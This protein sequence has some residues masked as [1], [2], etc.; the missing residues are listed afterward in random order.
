MLNTRALLLATLLGTVLQVGMVVAGH[1]NKSIAGLFAIGGMGF[2]LIAG[3]AYAFWAGGGT[4]TLLALGGLAAGAICALIGIFVSYGMGDVPA[5]LLALGTLSSAVTGALGGIIGKFLFRAAGVVAMFAVL[6]A[7]AASAGSQTAIPAPIDTSAVISDA[8]I[9]A[10]LQAVWDA[11]ATSEGLRSWLAPQADID[12]RV[13]GLLRANYN[14]KGS[15]ADPQTIH[16][17][18]LSLDPG[19]MLSIKVSKAPEGF[20]FANAIQHM[21]TVVY[22]EPA[23][24]NLT[25]V[26]VVGLG[27]RADPESQRMRAFFDQGNATTLK[28]L[29]RRFAKRGE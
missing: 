15:L 27:F 28:Q 11:W 5:S 7:T 26:R 20:P 6:T 25:R 2:S 29:Q 24:Q 14:A 12:L 21:W 16:N 19:R 13:G 8:I 18:V 9:E 1:S 3:I 10:P 23:G 17:T 22:F 4:T